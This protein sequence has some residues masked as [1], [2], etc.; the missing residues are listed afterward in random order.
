[1]TAVLKLYR[2]YIPSLSVVYLSF[3]SAKDPDWS[4]RYPSN[5][6]DV[7]TLIPYETFEEWAGTMEKKERRL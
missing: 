7:I 5:T 4:N 2:R 3:P 6:I 1:M